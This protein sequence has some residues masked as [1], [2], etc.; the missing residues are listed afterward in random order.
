MAHSRNVRV[1]SGAHGKVCAT[2]V[3]QTGPVT[4]TRRGRTKNRKVSPSN[5]HCG[6]RVRPLE[7]RIFVAA[8]VRRTKRPG[9]VVVFSFDSSLCF[10][11][12]RVC[13]QTAGRVPLTDDAI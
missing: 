2:L 3:V 6:G 9:R 12:R 8:D 4:S 11:F 13:S 7:I 10:F 1:R 5:L